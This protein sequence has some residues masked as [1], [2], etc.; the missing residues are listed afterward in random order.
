MRA[1]N[2]LGWHRTVSPIPTI[3][4]G[5]EGYGPVSFLRLWVHSLKQNINLNRD[6]RFGRNSELP[7]EDPYLTGEYAAGLFRTVLLIHVESQVT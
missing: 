6:P 1:L 5:L 2:T 4:I 7:S 3:Q